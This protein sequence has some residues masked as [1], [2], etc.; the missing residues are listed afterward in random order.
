MADPYIPALSFNWLTPVYDFVLRWVMRE[1]TFKRALIAQAQ[2]AG[3]HR[4][5][6]VGCGTA[7]LTIM[8]K[9]ANPGA[10]VIGLDG[11]EGVLAI[12][13]AKAEKAGAQITLDHGLAFDLPYPDGSFDRA[14]SSLVFHHLT[15]DNKQRT[16]K[17]IFRV[18]RPGGQLHLADFG[19]PHSLYGRLIAPLVRRLEEAADNVDGRLPH[20][21]RAAGFDGVVETARF[22]SALGPLSLYRAQKPG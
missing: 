22:T 3:G 7:T 12:G 10:E 6:D 4:V 9:Q 1:E 15:A 17:E 14:L 18:L 20:M 16:L 11:D 8:V 13:R 19:P 2:I 21:F 5:L